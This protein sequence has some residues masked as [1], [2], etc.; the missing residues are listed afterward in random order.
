MFLCYDF[1]VFKYNWL[2]VIKNLVTGEYVKIAD[3]RDSLVKFYEKHKN[4]IWV[5]FNSRSYDSNI[6]KSILAG[7]NPFDMNEWIITKKRKGW[8]FSDSLRQFQLYDYDVYLENG[9]S[10]KR[11]EGYLG[12]N[13]HESS[14]DFRINRPLTQ[15]ELDET[16]KYCTHDVNCTEEVFCRRKDEWDASWGLIK[17]FN[18]PISYISKT[19]AQLASAI[20]D[21]KKH[22]FDDEWDFDIDPCIQINKYTQVLDWFKDPKNRNNNPETKLDT[23]I[24]G[25]PTTYGWG[26]WHSAIPNY[27]GEGDFW[28]PDCASMYPSIILSKNLMS[29]S[30]PS[31]V[32]FRKIRDDRLLYKSQGNP[33]E[34]ILKRLINSVFGGFGFD[35]SPLCDKNRLHRV[36]MYGQ[37]AI[38]DLIEKT[39]DLYTLI[40]GNTDSI[41]IKFDKGDTH[42]EFLRRCKLW[43]ERVGLQL[44]YDKF[45]KIVQKDVNNYAMILDNGKI[46]CKG[47]ILKFNNPLD[48]DVSI[49]ND[50]V[51]S[52]LLNGVPPEKTIQD[53]DDLIKFQKI[54]HVSSLYKEALK[55][56]TFSKESYIKEETGRR[57]T[58]TVWNNDGITFYERT[59]RVFASKDENEGALY[60]KKEDK[61]PEKFANCPEHCFIEN[62]DIRG[63]KCS[64]YPMLDK[65]WY[66]NEA[67]K[68][69][70]L[71]KNGK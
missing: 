45:T 18:L 6:M 1:E 39:E 67:W 20:L 21:A 8:E 24:S 12:L 43:E 11:L 10:L 15:E 71:F 32:K 65:E 19:K 37:L 58:R 31:D 61:N 63:K 52:Y 62:G 53:C 33:I 50:S 51:R 60:K 7:F 69:I 47:S 70:G 4:F 22:N 30:C 55:N 68:R 16:F 17:L 54:F 64:D 34:K 29:R 23:V 42:D 36:C 49:I 13:I 41:F 5:G 25:V 3:D 2:V 44:D 57:N 66:I 14:V 26:G 40:G 9:G 35:Y 38:L 48:N 56:C 27:R 46:K 28:A 59:F